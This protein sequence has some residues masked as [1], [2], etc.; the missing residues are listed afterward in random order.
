[1]VISESMSYLGTSGWA[2]CVKVRRMCRIEEADGVRSELAVEGLLEGLG[3]SC[4]VLCCS[5]E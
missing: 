3:I 1:M 4:I 5:S 2:D